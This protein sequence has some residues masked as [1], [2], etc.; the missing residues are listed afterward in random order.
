ML[1]TITV[2]SP[3]SYESRIGVL[4]LN[5]RQSMGSVQHVHALLARL[6]DKESFRVFV[7]TPHDA[8]GLMEWDEAPGVTVWRLPL[9]TSVSERTGSAARISALLTNLSLLRTILGLAARVRKQHI[10]IIHTA[11]TPR[12][13]LIGYLLSR[14]TG[15]ALVIHWH[16]SLSRDFAPGSYPWTWRLAFRRASAIFAV[17]EPSRRSL[18]PL[19]LPEERIWILHNGIDTQRFRPDLDGQHVRQELA[20]PMGAPLILLP[21][22]MRPYKGQADLLRAVALLRDRGRDVTVALVGGDDSVS[23]PGSGPLYRP[24]LD[25]LTE[26][27]EIRDRVRFVDHRHDMPAVMVAS[28]IVA[29]PSHDDP[30]PLVVIEA[31]A[32]GRPVIGA[33]SG[34][35]PEL[36]ADGISGLLVPSGSPGALAE[37]IERILIDPKL[38]E[39]LGRNG[40]QHVEARF[41]QERMAHNAGQLYRRVLHERTEGR[42][43]HARTRPRGRDPIRKRRGG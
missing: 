7:A 11:V 18:S 22:R 24:Q 37:A 43:L 14:L 33:R 23:L 39:R 3:V 9:G 6:L 5:T 20:V 36:I 10:E 29:V 4:I 31:L 13:A 21:G 17:S 16:L 35:I 1:I 2:A 28:D 19:G 38:A 40:R 26:E 32:C 42:K 34:G 27:L 41:S 12:D 25:T 15:A 8:E 30:L